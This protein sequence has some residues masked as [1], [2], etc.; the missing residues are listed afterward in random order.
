[1]LKI[2]GNVNASK[3]EEL[4]EIISVLENAN[5]EIAYVNDFLVS[6]IKE[7]ESLDEN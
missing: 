7:V 5:Y 2:V 4:D 1:M 3:K 6:V